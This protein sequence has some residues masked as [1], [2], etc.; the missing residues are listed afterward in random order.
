MRRPR[1][2]FSVRMMALVVALVGLNLATAIAT[3]RQY[4]RR[5]IHPGM[6]ANGRGYISYREDGT[7]EFGVGNAEAGWRRTHILRQPPPP[8]LLQTWSPV[9]AGAAATILA[10]A[11]ASGR[12]RPRRA[13]AAALVILNLA[14]AVET[15]KSYPRPELIGAGN[16]GGG[17]SASENLIARLYRPGARGRAPPTLPRIWSPVIAGAAATILVIVAARVG[18]RSTGPAGRSAHPGPG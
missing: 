11:A 14:A 17:I 3:S 7:V 15:S 8:N 12:L 16:A 1:V 6:V 5:P 13:V 9:V 18:P 4:P 2:Q 10:L